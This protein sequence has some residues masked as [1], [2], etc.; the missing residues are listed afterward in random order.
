MFEIKLVIALEYFNQSD[1][2]HQLD[3]SDYSEI[4]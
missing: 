1:Q 2:P 3:N 4:N